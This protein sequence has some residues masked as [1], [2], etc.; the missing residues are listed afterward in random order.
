MAST[1]L[2]SSK[3]LDAAYV[4]LIVPNIYSKILAKELGLER[5]LCFVF[6]SLE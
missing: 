2:V 5:A 3:S 6:L 4:F 1:Y